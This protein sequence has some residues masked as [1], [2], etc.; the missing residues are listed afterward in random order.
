MIQVVPALAASC[1]T[2][3]YL[4]ALSRGIRKN[5]DRRM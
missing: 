5:G 2:S 4:G 3:R 1:H